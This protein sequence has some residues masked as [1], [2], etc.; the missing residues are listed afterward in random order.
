[1]GQLL[2]SRREN[3]NGRESSLAQPAQTKSRA[4]A[5]GA[6]R[7]QTE[8]I[9]GTGE[10]PEAQRTQEPG[11]APPPDGGARITNLL[12]GA[13]PLMPAGSFRLAVRR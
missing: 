9:T 5:P 7:V 4:A 2:G 8:A 3:P 6:V 1:L 12:A 13:V 10:T 11:A